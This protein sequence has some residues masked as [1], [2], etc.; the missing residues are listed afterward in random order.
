MLC[1]YMFNHKTENRPTFY[2]TGFCG[3]FSPFL[4]AARFS[5]GSKLLPL[6]KA[7]AAVCI[8]KPSIACR[9]NLQTHQ[10]VNP[11]VWVFLQVC[12]TPK[13]WES[14]ITSS[15]TP[16][17]QDEIWGPIS[18]CMCHNFLNEPPHFR[19]CWRHFNLSW[20]VF[21]HLCHT[22]TLSL[23]SQASIMANTMFNMSSSGVIMMKSKL[24]G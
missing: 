24:D 19:S 15:A 4:S 20:G 16:W 3:H 12:L 1:N 13:N 23:V 17:H 2:G 10:N 6:L 18:Y 11:H 22:I 8:W 5:W 21:A 9:L 7:T 14:S